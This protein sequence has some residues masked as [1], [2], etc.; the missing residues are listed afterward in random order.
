MEW[1]VWVGA[2]VSLLGLCGLIYCIKQVWSAKKAQLSDD[3]LKDV[4]R[5]VVPINTGSLFLS[6]FGLMIVVIGIAF[7]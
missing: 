5:Q 2:G 1:V 7:S 4:L 3:A 6:I